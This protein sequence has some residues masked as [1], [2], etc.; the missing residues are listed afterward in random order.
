MYTCSAFLSIKYQHTSHSSMPL[1][2]FVHKVNNHASHSGFLLFEALFMLKHVYCDLMYVGTLTLICNILL[3][4][5]N[6]YLLCV[7]MFSSLPPSFVLF[8]RHTTL[9]KNRSCFKKTRIMLIHE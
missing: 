7:L 5:N 4:S 2:R 6:K 3:R 8:V 1:K 9:R